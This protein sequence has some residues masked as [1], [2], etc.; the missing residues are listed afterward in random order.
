MIQFPDI[1]LPTLDRAGITSLPEID[2]SEAQSIAQIWLTSFA[3]SC[4]NADTQGILD[5]LHPSTPF[6]RDILALTWDFRTLFSPLKIAAL[7]DARLANAKLSDFV[8]NKA[9]TGFQQPFP[10]LAWIELVFNFQT[11][12][13]KCTGVVR[14]IPLSKRSDTNESGAITNLDDLE[15]KSHVVFMNLDSLTGFPEKIGSLRDIESTHTKWAAERDATAEFAG[16]EGDASKGPK[17]LLVGAGQSGLIIAARLKALGI[18]ALVVDK[19]ARIGDNWRGR[20]DSLS[21]HDPVCKL[22]T[23]VATN[24][25]IL[26]L[27]LKGTITCPTFHSHQ[28]GQHIA[29]PRRYVS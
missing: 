28:P 19:N 15:W 4:S 29:L 18:P 25:L 6:W 3:T 27:S 1:P 23:L 7:L 5:L 21:L 13:G 12:I 14:L 8:L 20:Y 9:Y 11:K 2:P 22:P 26:F 10:D 16:A 24:L 17:V